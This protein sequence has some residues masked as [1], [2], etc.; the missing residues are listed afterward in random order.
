VGWHFWRPF[1]KFDLFWP[2]RRRFR[3]KRYM[4]LFLRIRY[5]I[6]EKWQFWNSR[7]MVTSIW[8]VLIWNDSSTC[9][10]N[11]LYNNLQAR[12]W[13]CLWFRGKMNCNFWFLPGRCRP[14]SR[15]PRDWHDRAVHATAK[16]VRL[17]PSCGANRSGWSKG[18]GR[19]IPDTLWAGICQPFGGESHSV[20]LNY[21][22]CRFFRDDSFKFLPE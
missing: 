12:S 19:Y 8:Q 20:S 3:E 16:I 10:S 1:C 21:L 11:S 13:S 15:F 14:W 18:N 2:K 5:W 4:R 7:P 22:K 6:H 17:R 9:A